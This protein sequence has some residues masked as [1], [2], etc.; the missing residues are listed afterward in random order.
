[1]R[2]LNLKSVRDTTG[3]LVFSNAKWFIRP[4]ICW[5]IH[6]FEATFWTSPVSIF[7]PFIVTTY[8]AV[9]IVC[10]HLKFT[11]LPIADSFLATEFSIPT[12]TIV[13]YNKKKNVFLAS[14]RSTEFFVIVQ[15]NN[16]YIVKLT[17]RILLLIL[18]T[19]LLAILMIFAMVELFSEVFMYMLIKY[20]MLFQF[21]NEYK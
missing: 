12:S 17:Y 1:M 6:Y 7:G 18:L 4:A 16:I 3:F 11:K 21:A 15:H 13:S 10:K 2:Y 5:S 14:V 20:K 8:V 9:V 19:I